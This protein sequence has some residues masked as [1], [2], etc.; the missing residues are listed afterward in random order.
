MQKEHGLAMHRTTVASDIELLK[1]AGCRI[2]SELRLAKGYFL[3]AGR[4]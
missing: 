2:Q 3:E 1:K 4:V